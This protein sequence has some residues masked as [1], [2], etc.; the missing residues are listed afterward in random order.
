MHR[1]GHNSKGK[2][3]QLLSDAPHS[4]S[5]LGQGVCIIYAS[6]PPAPTEPAN[7]MWVRMWVQESP[8]TTPKCE[9]Q[10]PSPGPTL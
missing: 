10:I 8:K 6:P 9:I 7:W 5:D 4:L 1:E 2:T 3:Q